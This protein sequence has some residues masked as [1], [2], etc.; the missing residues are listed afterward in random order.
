MESLWSHSL[1]RRT[2][3]SRATPLGRYWGC[4]APVPGFRRPGE[5]SRRPGAAGHVIM[6]PPWTHYG[7]KAVQPRFGVELSQAFAMEP[8]W[9]HYGVTM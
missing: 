5:P 6:E 3:G 2:L 4:K 1:H 8:L 9:S 7:V